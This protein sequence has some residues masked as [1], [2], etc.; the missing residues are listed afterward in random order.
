MESYFH[1]KS[2]GFD[3]LASFINRPVVLSGSAITLPVFS[4]P[5]S[6]YSVYLIDTTIQSSTSPLVRLFM[7]K[8]KNPEFEQQFKDVFIPA[9]KLSVNDFLSGN[10]Q[11]LFEQLKLISNFQIENMREMIPG[12]FR[13]KIETLLEQN[14]PVKLLGSGGGGYLLAFVPDRKK[15][16]AELKSLQV[17]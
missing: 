11:E 10:S 9:N 12:N 16:P 15:L 2:S 17:F 14:I 4:A 13:P 7:E 8:M 3:P 6:G 5:K 1:G